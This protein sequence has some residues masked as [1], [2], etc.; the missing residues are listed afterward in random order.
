MNENNVLAVIL[1]GGK[2]KRFGRDKA[3][4]MLG[5]KTILEHVIDKIQKIYSEILVISNNDKLKFS[6][7]KH[8]YSK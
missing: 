8:F 6:K 4:V 3:N 1:A 5:D 7:K 2:S